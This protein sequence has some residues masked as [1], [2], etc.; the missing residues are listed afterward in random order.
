MFFDVDLS[1]CIERN[2]RR[3]ENEKVEREAIIEMERKLEKPNVDTSWD[4][5]IVFKEIVDNKIENFIS[6]SFKNPVEV[7]GKEKIEKEKEEQRKIN[8]NNFVHNLDL[9]IRKIISNI[10]KMNK[11]EKTIQ[12]QISVFKKEFLEEKRNQYLKE[13]MNLEDISKQFQEKQM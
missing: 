4:Q 7:Y 13:E 2:N 5:A 8:L 12:K 10:L 1:V 9:S 6:E 3:E 11:P